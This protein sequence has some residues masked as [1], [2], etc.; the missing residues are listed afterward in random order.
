MSASASETVEEEVGGGGGG[1]MAEGDMEERGLFR[2]SQALGWGPSAGVGVDGGVGGGGADAGGG[3]GV[4]G[5]GREGFRRVES[6]GTVRGVD[7]ALGS[8]VGAGT[9]GRRKGARR[10]E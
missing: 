1:K 7:G 3:G 6:I 5:A 10:R 9:V 4:L 8:G 2:P